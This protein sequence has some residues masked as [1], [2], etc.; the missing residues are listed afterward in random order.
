MVWRSIRITS[1][2]GADI[3]IDGIGGE[4]LSEAPS[5][6]YLFIQSASTLDTIVLSLTVSQAVDR[7]SPARCHG[8]FDIWQANYGSSCSAVKDIHRHGTPPEFQPE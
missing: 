2:Y 8:F 3:V 6:L 5:G 4:V 7:G 1:G